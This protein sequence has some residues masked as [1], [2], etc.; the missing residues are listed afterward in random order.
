[1]SYLYRQHVDVVMNRERI[2][3]TS[4]LRRVVYTG[5]QTGQNRHGSCSWHWPSCARNAGTPSAWRP[6]IIGGRERRVI[7]PR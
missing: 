6:G 4:T 7:L 1:M 2:K 3:N 5:R